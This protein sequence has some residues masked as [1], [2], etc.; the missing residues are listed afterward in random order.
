MSSLFITILNMSLTGAFVIGLICLV[1]LALK[2]IPKMISYCL[3]AAAGFRLIFPFSIESAFSLIPFNPELIPPDISV[4][5]AAYAGVVG[6]NPFQVWVTIGLFLWLFGVTAMFFY[7]VASY[8]ILKDKLKTATCVE[9]NICELETIKTPFVFGIFSPKIYLP[10][11]LTTWERRYI[12]LHE[13]THIRRCDNIVKYVA[14]LI[15]CLHWFNPLVWLA[16]FLMGRDMEMSCDECVLKELSDNT[17]KEYSMALLSLAT[18]QRILGEIPLAFGDGYIDGRI[19]NILHLKRRSPVVLGVWMVL[20]VL[21]GMSLSV[22]RVSVGVVS[23]VP[24]QYEVGE[25]TNDFIT[26]WQCCDET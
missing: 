9:A 7:G 4:Q 11:D 8:M 23:P 6:S 18:E 10:T 22:N 12:V 1:R 15:L 5:P 17:K 2:K 14:Y 21:F 19:R 20:V 3:W 25:G 16:F 26:P 24:A 13:Q